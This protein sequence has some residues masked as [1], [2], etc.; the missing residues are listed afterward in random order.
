LWRV[1][2]REKAIEYRRLFGLVLKEGDQVVPV[3]GLLETTKGHLGPWDVL[4]GVLEVLK[5][6][7]V[8][9][10]RSDCNGVGVPECHCPR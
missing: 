6:Q 1:E 7:N 5:L 4:L 9:L 8:S 3:L 10:P 2:G